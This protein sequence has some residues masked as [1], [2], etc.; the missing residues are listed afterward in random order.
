MGVQN[1]YYLLS[2]HPEEMEMLIN[3]IHERE[4][5]AFE[6]MAQGPCDII[7]LCENTSTFYISPE[8]YRKYNCPHV[9][10]FVD[11]IHAAGKTAIIHMCGY[12]KNL[13]HQIK[14]TGLDGIHA[15]TAPPIGDTPAELALDVISEDLIIIAAIPASVFLSGPVEGIASALDELYTPRLRRA[16]Y[17]GGCGAD[18]TRVPLERFQAFADW[19]SRNGD[20]K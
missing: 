15:L 17:S 16:N 5:K 19:M 8:I 6:I 20:L 18:G 10:D 4:L 3:T 9:C 12:V 13:L 1:F 2:D 7:I 14:D 11:I